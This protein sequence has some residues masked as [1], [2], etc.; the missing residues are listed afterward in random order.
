MDL[1][2][3]QLDRGSPEPRKFCGSLIWR[4]P[5]VMC[6]SRPRNLGLNGNDTG[7]IEEKE[8]AV[9]AKITAPRPSIEEYEAL[10][11]G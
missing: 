9:K 1:V 2:E 10:L 4:F 7:C 11:A 3:D 8:Q 6:R 5:K